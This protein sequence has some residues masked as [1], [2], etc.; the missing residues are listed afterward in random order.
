VKVVI[1]PDKFK[2]TLTATEAAEAMARGWRSVRPDD[3]VVLA[4]MADGGTGTLDVLAAVVGASELRHTEAEDARGRPR[5]VPW[6]QLPDGRAVVE[7]A[8]VIGVDQLAP[9]ERDPWR[10]SSAGLGQLL[11]SA[12]AADP[13][14]ILVGLGGTANVDGGAGCVAAL[15]H[16][17]RTAD[18]APLEV[19]RD[20][21]DAVAEVELSGA[22]LPPVELISDVDNPLLGPD[23]AA[24]V[25]GPQKGATAEDVPVLDAAIARFAD[26][27]ERAAGGTWRHEPGAGAAG[28]LGFALLAVAR[29]EVRPGSRTVGELVGLDQALAAAAV[30]LTGEGQLDRQTDFGKAPAFVAARARE[31]GAAVYAVVGRVEDGAGSGFDRVADLGPEGQ[32]RAAELVAERAAELARTHTVV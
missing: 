15:G 21:L 18:G 22:A 19:G 10:A 6:L 5:R 23:G 4:P 12:A 25:Y 1:A 28:G 2:G 8:A 20:R 26:V 13:T 16:R 11:R 9:D 30:V 31:V 29:A 32:V 27:V 3:E 7:A 14:A 24:H 17:L